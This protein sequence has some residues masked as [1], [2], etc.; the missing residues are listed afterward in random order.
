[1]KGSVEMYALFPKYAQFEKK[2]KNH[3]LFRNFFH[4]SL[5]FVY[6]LNVSCKPVCNSV[7]F[8]P[9]DVPVHELPQKT[10]LPLAILVRHGPLNCKA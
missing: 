6:I 9:Y 7:C 5:H 10:F 3:E 2:K 1:M 4:Q 8:P